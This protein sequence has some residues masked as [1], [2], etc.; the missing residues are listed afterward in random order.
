M[1]SASVQT[2]LQSAAKGLSQLTATVVTGVGGE[3]D[4]KAS[5]IC[6]EKNPTQKYTLSH[7]TTCCI[8]FRSNLLG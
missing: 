6:T 3:K 1:T 4:D 2:Y 8:P 7:A 5:E